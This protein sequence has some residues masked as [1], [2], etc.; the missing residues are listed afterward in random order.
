MRLAPIG[1]HKAVRISALQNLDSQ[2]LG[3]TSRGTRV[4][5]LIMPTRIALQ[6]TEVL[7][8]KLQAVF[9]RFGR[10]PM[11]THGAGAFAFV[12][13]HVSGLSCSFFTTWHPPF[14]LTDPALWAAGQEPAALNTR[15][16]KT[17]QQAD[18]L[19]AYQTL[20]VVFGAACPLPFGHSPGDI[21]GK[22]KGEDHGH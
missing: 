8:I 4:E 16:W 22:M 3:L 19:L 11:A 12:V 21:W 9:Q 18:D 1:P 7:S 10:V 5:Q 2:E 20:T 15:S 17:T 13:R 14:S 6:P